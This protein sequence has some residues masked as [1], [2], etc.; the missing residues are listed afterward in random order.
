MTWRTRAT[1]HAIRPALTRSA[2]GATIYAWPVR[3]AFKVRTKSSPG[4]HGAGWHPT[5]PVFSGFTPTPEALAAIP[6][7][8]GAF[9]VDA[10]FL[11]SKLR[12]LAP[13]LV[14]AE[15]RVSTELGRAHTR[16]HGVASGDP[17]ES[18]QRLQLW[19]IYVIG[20]VP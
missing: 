8:S 11:Q 10:T 1:N 20:R 18:M 6:H 12:L 9:A 17:R 16:S 5:R 4:F 7:A 19:L 2:V 14:E 3:G 13:H 15:E